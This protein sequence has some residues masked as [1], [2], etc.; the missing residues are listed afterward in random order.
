MAIYKNYAPC[1]SYPGCIN[2][3]SYHKQWKKPNG[4]LGYKWKKFCDAHRTTKKASA[5]DWKMAKG[6]ENTDGR[7]GFVCTATIIAPEQLD[8][9]HRDGDHR[10]DSQDN[11]ECLC[12]NCHIVVTV[13]NGDHLNTYNN[14]A[15]WPEGL[16]TWE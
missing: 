13:Q 14:V 15:T 2:K 10:N 4:T 5:D 16:I 3:V 6:C 12:G 11:L 7:Y 8:V 9:H 1:C